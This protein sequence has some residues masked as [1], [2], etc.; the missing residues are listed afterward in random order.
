MFVAVT[1]AVVLAPLAVFGALFLRRDRGGCG[2]FASTS[3]ALAAATA[4][5]VLFAVPGAIAATPVTV[6]V[7]GATSVGSLSTQISSNNVY[8]GLID[9][10]PTAKA[11]FAALALPLVRIH[12]GDDSG[13]P[14]MPAIRQ[15]Q[16][17]FSTLDELVNDETS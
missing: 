9:D 1:A 8:A 11:N 7:A 3:A 15:N 4:V 10:N 12:V 14:A 17:S 16:W 6:T 13:R 2:R 5:F